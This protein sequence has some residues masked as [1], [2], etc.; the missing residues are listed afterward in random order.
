MIG[1][2][3]IANITLAGVNVAVVAGLLYVYTSNFGPL[4]SKLA[5]GLIAFSSVLVLQNIVAA[6]IYWGLAQTYTAAV[7]APILLITALETTGLL[8]LLWATW[9]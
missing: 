5:L 2:F 6:F 1:P 9:R 7:A 8:L 3:W 4:R